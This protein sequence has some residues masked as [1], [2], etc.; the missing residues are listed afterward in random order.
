MKTAAGKR[1]AEKRD[2]FLHTFYET[3]MREIDGVE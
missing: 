3:F 1:R 2:Q